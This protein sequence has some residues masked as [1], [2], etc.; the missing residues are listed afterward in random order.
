MA[1]PTKDHDNPA[2]E[3]GVGAHTKQPQLD[4][5]D[6]QE[7]RIETIETI[8]KIMVFSPTRLSL[9]VAVLLFATKKA[10][11]AFNSGRIDLTRQDWLL[12]GVFSIT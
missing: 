7:L 5:Q 11:I 4:G 9:L 10:I 1:K 8:R 12:L 3:D 2:L 6:L